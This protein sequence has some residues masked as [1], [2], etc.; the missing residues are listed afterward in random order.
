MNRQAQLTLD[1]I[2]PRLQDRFSS[3]GPA[4]WN[5]FQS[6]LETN[7]ERL[8]LLLMRLYGQQYDFFY[9]LEAIL[10]MAA[11]IWLTR[12]T[13]LR[14]LD[15]E[16]EEDPFWFHS[17]E[18]LGGVCYVDLFAENLEGIRDKIPYFSELGLTYLHLMPLFLSPEQL[19]AGKP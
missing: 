2:L 13:E 15:A 11:R 10:E 8:F 1:R 4:D 17:N 6:R 5:P 12:S 9:H 14:A 7:F 18:T 19:S 3:A 16:R